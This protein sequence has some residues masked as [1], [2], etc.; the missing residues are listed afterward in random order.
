MK[1]SHRTIA[2]VETWVDKQKTAKLRKLLVEGWVVDREPR[3][4]EDLTDEEIRALVL[5]DVKS[6]EDNVEA[7]LETVGIEAEFS[8]DGGDD[9]DDFADDEEE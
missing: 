4:I 2:K 3:D 6:E 9:D 8:D 1:L 5:S 7:A